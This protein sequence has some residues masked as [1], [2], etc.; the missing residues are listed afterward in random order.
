VS[1]IGITEDEWLTAFH[2]FEQA[3]K[4]KRYGDWIYLV[5]AR[6]YSNYSGPKNEEA[7][8]KEL[9]SISLK[10]KEKLGYPMDTV[11]YCMDTPINNKS[12][13]INQK[14]EIINNNPEKTAELK[15]KAHE[16]IGK[17]L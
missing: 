9:A 3:G 17:K 10:V 14:Q 12:E 7:Y 13:I 16:L 2:E 6:R 1:E 4:V 11:S 5:N 15:R 8:K